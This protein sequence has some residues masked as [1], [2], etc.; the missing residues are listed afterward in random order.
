MS[1]SAEQAR[2]IQF[3]EATEIAFERDACTEEILSFM[4]SMAI[5]SMDNTHNQMVD[6]MSPIWMHL[7]QNPVVPIIGGYTPCIPSVVWP[8]RESI[9]L[10][11]M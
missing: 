7:F 9:L 3:H 10:N 4:L 8:P 5:I 1:S 11:N 6:S 2:V